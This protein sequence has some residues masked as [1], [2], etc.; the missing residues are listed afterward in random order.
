MGTKLGR[1]CLRSHAVRGMLI[2]V[3]NYGYGA[4]AVLFS[5]FHSVTVWFVV[6]LNFHV[7]K[8][9]V[10]GICSSLMDTAL[11]AIAVK[12]SKSRNNSTTKPLIQNSPIL[13]QD[14]TVLSLHCT[15]QSLIFNDC[16]DMWN[17]YLTEWLT[18]LQTHTMTTICLWGS[19]H[20]GITTRQSQC[21]K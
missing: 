8:Q 13:V 3:G 16:G 19:A 6:H 18:H 1:P 15:F 11:L 12:V 4:L 14:N 20:W 2:K 10:M 7:D 21:S 17:S 5:G 9:P